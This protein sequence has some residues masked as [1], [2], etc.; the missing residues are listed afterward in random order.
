MADITMNGSAETNGT[1]R[2][3]TTS[4]KEERNAWQTAGSAAFDFRS[5]ACP[6][7]SEMAS[8]SLFYLFQGERAVFS[9]AYPVPHR[10]PH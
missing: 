1:H 9:R 6:F 5:I 7:S 8:P 10:V 3:Y 2:T 4:P